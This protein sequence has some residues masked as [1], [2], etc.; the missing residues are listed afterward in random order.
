MGTVFITGANRGIGKAIL[1]KFA[2][3]HFDAIVSTRVRYNEFEEECH[4]IEKKYNIKIHH[5]YMDLSDRESIKFGLRQFSTLGITPSVLIN[6][7][8]VFHEK[9]TF[10]TRLE[11]MDMVFQINYFAAVQITQTISKKMLRHG[12]A[13][14]NVSSVAS[15]MKQPL[16]TCY[17]ASK[18]ALNRFTYSLAQE[19]APFNIRVNAIAIGIAN[20]DMG[21]KLSEKSLTAIKSATALKRVCDSKEIADAVYYLS[22]EESSFITGQIIRVDG[23]LTI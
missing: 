21:D 1:L 18:A 12:G 10:L 5:I 16:A 2:E 15:M 11:E 4:D 22:T 8:G 3:K 19:L 6:N 9:T 14:V 13:V 20:T 23:G 17:G 7:A